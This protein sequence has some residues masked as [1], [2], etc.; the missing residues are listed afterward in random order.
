MT[1]KLGGS[2]VSNATQTIAVHKS[3]N[4]YKL[5]GYKWFTSA[6][7]S[8]I[9]VTL[10]RI[11]KDVSQDNSKVPLSLFVIKLRDENGN[12]NNLKI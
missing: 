5:Y 2:D 4:T 12:L 6:T 1:E 9:T 11:V 3:S 10:A 8:D 7:D